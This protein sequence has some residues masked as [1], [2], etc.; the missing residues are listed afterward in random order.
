MNF[1]AC[2][3][4]VS[5]LGARLLMCSELVSGCITTLAIVRCRASKFIRH[6]PKRFSRESDSL[7]RL[8]CG[9]RGRW[10]CCRPIQE[11]WQ[12]GRR[13]EWRGRR[14][15]RRDRSPDDRGYRECIFRTWN[16]RPY[17]FALRLLREAC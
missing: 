1:A 10:E 3:A 14:A 2:R 8:R 17:E 12:Y 9:L 16:G 4:M 6:G 15:S 5:P 11:E 7:S 13:V